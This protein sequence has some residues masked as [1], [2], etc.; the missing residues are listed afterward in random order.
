MNVGVI[1]VITQS[2]VNTRFTP[3]LKDIFDYTKDYH[4]TDS[5]LISVISQRNHDLANADHE[6]RL[7]P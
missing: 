7:I 6:L 2:R 3:T 5:T 1:L 4:S